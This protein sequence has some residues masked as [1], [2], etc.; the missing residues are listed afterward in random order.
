[1]RKMPIILFSLCLILT[2]TFAL[3]Q[4]KRMEISGSVGYSFSNGIDID[5]VE[6][7]GVIYDRISPAS[8]FAFDIQ[9]DVFLSEGFSI[10]FNWGR[11]ES[12]LRARARQAPDRDFT[13][14]DVNNFHG[15][16]TY[17]FGD[18]DSELRP[19]I[20]GGLGATHYDPSSI[21]GNSSNSR[22]RFSTTWGGGVKIFPSEHL[23]FRAGVRWTP[24]YIV[25]TEGGIWC[26][27]WYPWYCWHVGN[28]QF[29]HQFEMGGGV[30]VRF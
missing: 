4:E 26:D 28:D 1:M 15:I 24:T 16:F 18:E 22:T 10:G 17:N 23:G 13:D 20:F 14:M 11:Q 19:Y 7:E 21:E 6:Y 30:I 9:G 2:A 29:S 25:T 5:N 27:P 3:A 8:G 12:Q